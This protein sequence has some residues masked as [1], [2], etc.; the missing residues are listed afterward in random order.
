MSAS[1]I[2][3]WKAISMQRP[4]PTAGAKR[5]REDSDE[6]DNTSIVSRTPSPK[7]FSAQEMLRQGIDAYAR[8]D[9][10]EEEIATLE[11]RIKSTNIGYSMLAKLGWKEGQGLGA[12]GTGRPDPIPFTV[13]NDQMG[14]GKANLDFAM[15]DATVAQRRDL[16][17][18]RQTRE[19]EEARKIREDT[20]AKQAAIQIEI[21]K[22]LRPFYCEACDKQFLNVGQYD[23]HCNSYAHHHRVREKDLI[24]S[25]KVGRESSSVR[26][27][28]E[29][30][31]EER[32][33]K[34]MARA[35]G[36]KY[37]APP[38]KKLLPAA[39]VPVPGGELSSL[40]TPSSSSASK[41]GGWAS[42]GTPKASS[43]S[44]KGGWNR[45]GIPAEPSSTNDPPAPP[46]PTESPPPPPQ[47]APPPL[48]SSVDVPTPPSSGVTIRA[49]PKFRSSGKTN[50]TS[51]MEGRAVLDSTLEAEPHRDEASDAEMDQGDS[52]P[53][54]PKRMVIDVDALY[55]MTPAAAPASRLSAKT[56]AWRVHAA[57]SPS[58]HV[59][60]RFDSIAPGTESPIGAITGRSFS[61]RKFIQGNK[62]QEEPKPRSWS[63][64]ND[65][66]SAPPGWTRQG[67]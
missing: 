42:I 1:T 40:N 64:M 57:P 20:V 44:S 63:P 9:S 38:S 49:A 21:T 54:S 18:E 30:K 7:P 12:H 59:G 43:S 15:I 47:E 11:T 25:A 56:P 22:T 52:P 8:G 5:A 67:E 55:P 53:E 17:S 10:L 34:R 37:T 35:A 65:L 41:P 16:E 27:E 61:S 60:S 2:A 26:A 31:R 48:P 28:K 66:E 6:E 33:M 4:E 24:A 36:I 3:R 58:P 46:P 23:E 13:K 32:D 19:T 50:L 14:L 51:Q 45:V 39:E 29:R 62:R